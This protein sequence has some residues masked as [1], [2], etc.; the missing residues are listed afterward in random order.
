MEKFHL[1]LYY[2]RLIVDNFSSHSVYFIY[3]VINMPDKNIC[4]FIPIRNNSSDL[5]TINF[6]YET[7]YFAN[8]FNITPIRLI[9]Q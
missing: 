6:V 4:K 9:L 8:D 7:S 2:F 5:I 3:G 1:Y